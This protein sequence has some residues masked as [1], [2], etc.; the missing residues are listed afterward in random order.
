MDQ[1][2]YTSLGKRAYS[3]LLFFH[4]TICTL[5]LM[6]LA[7]KRRARLDCWERAGKKKFRQISLTVL[8]T[9]YQGTVL[10]CRGRGHVLGASLLNLPRIYNYCSTL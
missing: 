6:L 7:S 5:T 1:C 10:L 8:Q 9:C 2:C 4:V 3:M